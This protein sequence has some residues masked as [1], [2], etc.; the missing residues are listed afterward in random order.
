MY[1]LLY[2]QGQL[3]NSHAPGLAKY[4]RAQVAGFVVDV[5][6]KVPDEKVNLFEELAEVRLQSS[7]EF[8]GKI[9]L[10]V[11]VLYDVADFQHESPKRSTKV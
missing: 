3:V 1:A 2:T 5:V 7:E 8:Q 11:S 6:V 9:L 4:S 10:N